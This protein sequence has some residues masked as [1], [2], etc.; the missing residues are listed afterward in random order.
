MTEPTPSP[1]NMKP[2]SGKSVWLVTIVANTLSTEVGDGFK[3]AAKAA[4]LKPTVIYGNGS[5]SSWNSAVSEA[6]AAHAN[7]LNL[8]GI[9]PAAVSAP[10][11]HAVAQKMTIVDTLD[12]SSTGPLYKG[13]F[14]HLTENA[15]VAGKDMAYWMLAKSKCSNV[16]AV[17]FSPTVNPMLVTQAQ[18]LAATMKS[19]GCR[20]CT[21]S[22]QNQDQ[23]ALATA[24]GPQVNSYLTSNPKTTYL[25]EAFDGAVPYIEPAI[26]SHSSI[27]LVSH[28]GVDANLNQIRTGAQQKYDQAL[29][30]GT[31]IGWALIDQLGRGM[32]GQ[33]PA[34]LSIPQRVVDSSNV[35]KAN[36]S[37]FSGFTNYQPVFLKA[38]GLG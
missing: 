27:P 35:G 36:A 16:H 3:A 34:N 4:G 5:A 30:P 38:W 18:T 11:A 20:G 22:V 25:M 12:I 32:A 24:L 31:W 33:K 9:N 29:P 1:F 15:N 19:S 7:G 37:L 2:N 26:A 28:D 14:A 17:M 6:V 10:L 8:F 23:N 21:I 13:V